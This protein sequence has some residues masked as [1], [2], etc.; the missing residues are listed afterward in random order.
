V[1]YRL[2]GVRVVELY[3][4]LSDRGIEG[5]WMWRSFSGN[6]CVI[7]VGYGNRVK[8]AYKGGDYTCGE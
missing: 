1:C 7:E 6:H 4:S 3:V 5:R 8:G 2:F